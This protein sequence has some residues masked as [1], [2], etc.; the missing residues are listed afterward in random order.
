MVVNISY[1]LT[2]LA[3]SFRPH[4][5]LNSLRS[6]FPSSSSTATATP[7]NFDFTSNVFGSVATAAASQNSASAAAGGVTLGVAAGALGAGA[8]AAAGAGSGGAAGGAGGSSAKAGS[9]SSHW[10]FQSK[11]VAHGQAAQSDS[12]LSDDADDIRSFATSHQTLL[13]RQQ[14]RLA[15]SGARLAASSR[16]RHGSLS[17]PHPELLRADEAG[18]SSIR[19]SGA[20]MQKRFHSA[21]AARADADADAAALLEADEVDVES[22]TDV[23]R[24]RRRASISN[25]PTMTLASPFVITTAPLGASLASSSSSR[26]VHTSSSP[27][28][29]SSASSPSSRTPSTSALP[30]APTAARTRRNSTSALPSASQ[31]LVDLA[32]PRTQ[33]PYSA[34]PRERR[35]PASNPAD[36]ASR[37]ESEAVQH[38]KRRR[39]R[40]EQLQDP[41]TS[42]RR[43]PSCLSSRAPNADVPVGKQE[44]HNAIIAAEKTGKASLVERAVQQY[45][46]DPTKWTTSV[47]NIAIAA[48]HRT[49]KP[50]DPLDRI[51]ELYNQLFDS[52]RLTPNRLSYEL[53][54][55]A[56]TVR[57]S[58]VVKMI[59]FLEKREKKK[60]L[61]NAARG[62]WHR[63]DPSSAAQGAEGA[64]ADAAAAVAAEEETDR[65]SQRER[66]RLE[67]LRG[68]EFDYFR[69][70]VQIYE[71]LGPL[72]DRL[73]SSVVGLL[74]GAA[75]LRGDVETALKL[76]E[77]I[78]KSK[79]QRP[80]SKAY[81]NLM[82]LHGEHDKDPGAVLEVL[83]A[84][85]AGRNSGAIVEATPA[86]KASGRARPA[87]RPVPTKH[88]HTTE[89]DFALDDAA[90]YRGGAA[91][92]GDEHVWQTAVRA[93]FQAGDAAAG[94]ALIDRLVNAQALPA[95]ERPVGYPASLSPRTIASFITCFI[96][97]GD[98]AS[99]RQWF[100]RSLAADPKLASLPF[101]A[102]PLYSAVNYKRGDLVN[103]FFREQLARTS[104]DLRLSISDV[105]TVI[106]FNLAR[107][108]SATTPD[109]VK[110]ALDAVIEF[111]TAFERISKADLLSSDLGPDFTVSTGLLGR[112]TEAMGSHGRFPEAAEAFASLAN[113]T[114]AILRDTP[115]DD[116]AARRLDRRARSQWVV[117]MTSVAAGALGVRPEWNQPGEASLEQPPQGDAVPPLHDAVKVV[118]WV[119]KLRLVV[120][121]H[122]VPAFEL[123]VV[124][125]YARA[126]AAA[127]SSS[128]SSPAAQLALSGDEWFTVIEAF[129]SVA[130]QVKHGHVET[131][132]PFLGFDAVFNDFL[133]AGVEIPIAGSGMRNY[134]AVFGALRASGMRPEHVR[135]VADRLNRQHVREA[136]PE[137]EPEPVVAAPEL[138]KATV[139]PTV[140]AEDDVASLASESV[141]AATS[142]TGRSSSSIADDAAAAA[143]AQYPTPPSTPPAYFAQLADVEQPAVAEFDGISRRVTDQVDNLLGAGKVNDAL[144][145]ALSQAQQG[146][147]GHPDAYGRLVEQ[148]GRQHRVAEARQ[149]YLVAYQALGAM[150]RSPEQQSVAWVLLEDRMIVALA[151][152][153]ELVDVGHHRD[154]L[155]QAGCAPSADAYAAMILNMKDTTDDA[156]VALTL[157]EESQRLNVRPNVYLFNT[158]I[159][160][161]S[162]ARRA[163][164]ALEY[165]ELMKHC[166]LRPSSITY[167]AIIN[168]CCKTG[169]D[170]SAAYLFA[171]MAADPDFKP[172]VP[173]YNT[174]IQFYT[175]TKPNRERALHYYGELVKAKVPPT[176]HTYKLLLD[177]YGTIGEPDLDMCQ[178]VFSELVAHR[179]V[180]VSGAHWASLLTAYGVHARQLDR[181][182]ALFD[183]IASHPTSRRSARDAPDAVPQPDAVVYEALLNVLLANER[184]DLCDQYLDEMRR[185]G[186]R[187]T[188]YVGNTLIKGYSAQGL[189]ERARA[190]FLA[191]AEPR[192]G[193]ASAGNHPV[194]RHAKHHHLAQQQPRGVD[195]PT[196]REPSTYEAMIR[197]ELKAGETVRA[198]EV[199]RLAEARAFPPA[200]IGRL[201][202]LLAA[203]GIEALPLA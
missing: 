93:L 112:I 61:A 51:V 36:A 90:A 56:F 21:M 119:N 39:F 111:R 52:E 41:A 24:S 11:S 66:E 55:K 131:S 138:A 20:E 70:A 68:P 186:V 29:S 126:R 136:A 42:V 102:L 120:G 113:I 137:P 107:S 18:L 89:P 174:M 175:S 127:S 86:D 8:G 34:V 146:R 152:A 59:S 157:F 1:K 123:V 75:T 33:T 49:R 155:L 23:L 110:T 158:L 94:Q 159:S 178:R 116:A 72:G 80:G 2:H 85:L 125:A 22:N 60:A 200:V 185:R 32:Q 121:W 19:L 109:E 191:M 73:H 196:Y 179:G 53:V 163:K 31:P 135:D 15:H 193:V 148:L 77:R 195:E 132:T 17:A 203:E 134:E 184:A 57:D 81:A 144:V 99:A 160:K 198:A 170:V 13:R 46:A 69:P 182:L 164:E 197:C 92:G 171:E 190:I 124:E 100:E 9:W 97:H 105:V 101:F 151:Q 189:P 194:D 114:R 162:R 79:Y 28:S 145:L 108:W 176:G 40:D 173:P 141:G 201:Q 12:S 180:T 26:A 142:A 202:K 139:S 165:F 71:A 63:P 161:L 48:L 95:A 67:A 50:N 30:P 167:G 147:L 98:E 104:K 7:V 27:S 38:H 172:R 129:A 6:A 83:E 154:R 35:P 143:P 188:A 133:E 156:A 14:S 115:E 106:D 76:F 96:A 4:H 150:H 3:Q 45:L 183:S 168:A 84:Y 58:E 74:L 37:G 82:T 169:D 91:I 47:H 149:V 25:R 62:I 192:A 187:M 87:F 5:H 88:G 140:A 117:R 43:S 177:A 199:L 78:E 54:L 44:R 64:D 10:G 130:A 166:G 128:S 181:A 65:M 153:G 122:V 103:Y 118:S 16:P